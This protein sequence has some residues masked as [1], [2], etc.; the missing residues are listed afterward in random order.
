[1]DAAVLA[2]DS[3]VTATT[4]GIGVTYSSVGRLKPGSR[5]LPIYASW[6][7]ERVVGSSGGIVPDRNAIR[8]SFRYYFRLF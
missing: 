2:E 3:K 5:G 4:L 6:S 8:V 1:V 7:Y